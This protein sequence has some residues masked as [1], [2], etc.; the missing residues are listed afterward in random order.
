M[1][2]VVMVFAKMVYAYALPCS[3]GLI[4]QEQLLA[5]IIV[6][7]M[8]SACLENV[9]VRLVGLEVTATKQ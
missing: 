8:V 9:C 1:I 7:L 5:P 2:A 4:A 6:Q 3:L